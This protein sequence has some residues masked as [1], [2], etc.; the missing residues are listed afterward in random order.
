MNKW[1]RILSTLLILSLAVAVFSLGAAADTSSTVTLDLDSGGKIAVVAKENG[2]ELYNASLGSS[3]SFSFSYSSSY[4]IDVTLNPY[5]GYRAESITI[6]NTNGNNIYYSK[7]YDSS[8]TGALS[9]PTVKNIDSVAITIVVHFTSDT[10]SGGGG[11]KYTLTTNAVTGSQLSTTGGSVTAG[12]SYAAG[13][14]IELS[15]VAKTG[16]TFAG[17]TCSAGSLSSTSDK[18]T[19]F[20]MPAQ[21]CMV[22][23]KFV[24]AQKHTL[25]LSS[26]TGG[27]ICISDWSNSMTTVT[28]GSYY[29]GEVVRLVSQADS[30]YA[31]NYWFTNG[32]GSLGSRYWYATDFEM[33]DSDVTVSAQFYKTSSGSSE[34]G[35]TTPTPPPTPTP[36]PGEQ[37]EGEEGNPEEGGS[38]VYIISVDQTEGGSVLCSVSTAEAGTAVSLTAIPDDGYKFYNWVS[39]A[40]GIFENANADK[41]TFTMP[42]SDT[43]I[44]ATFTKDDGGSSVTPSGDE[45][46]EGGDSGRSGKGFP[47]LLVGIGA[48]LIALI[49]GIVAVLSDRKRRVREEQ[50][51]DEEYYEDEPTALTVSKAKQR[52]KLFGRKSKGNF[53]PP[54]DDEDTDYNDSFFDDF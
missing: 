40:G 51:I 44:I 4:D 43:T 15:A 24:Q 7:S 29:P 52:K 20:T 12:G 38:A 23:A 30:G 14:V 13:E 47:W 1:K 19:K 45:E 49:I 31:L 35:G 21:D 50:E 5:D 33:P 39:T 27:K 46:P 10:P 36:T 3:G 11:T 6:R 9:I 25:T 48:A 26:A 41:T 53:D 17:W 37:D 22:S 32:G 28:S 42:A 8:D 2:S 54:E 34:P 18:T 16:Y